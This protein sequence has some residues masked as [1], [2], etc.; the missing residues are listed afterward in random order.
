M[1]LKTNKK[2]SECL[3]LPLCIF[4]IAKK[5]LD[6]LLESFCVTSVESTV[7]VAAQIS[8]SS[9]YYNEGK[10]HRIEIIHVRKCE[11][12][13]LSNKLIYRRILRTITNFLAIPQS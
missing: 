9:I 10:I 7:S 13:N 4:E 3:F 12:D 11:Q 8:D 2:L 6:Y 1:T 5:W